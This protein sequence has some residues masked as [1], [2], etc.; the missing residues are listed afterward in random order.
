M[1]LVAPATCHMEL[2]LTYYDYYYDDYDYD[3]YYYYCMGYFWVPNAINHYL[4]V[5][6]TRRNFYPFVGRF[7]LLD[8]LYLP[9]SLPT[10]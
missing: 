4:N 3:Y 10:Y 8:S 1:W 6:Y 5:V 7:Q 2:N 9:T